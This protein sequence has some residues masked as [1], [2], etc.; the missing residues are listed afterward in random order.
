MSK[1]VPTSDNPPDVVPAASPQ[2][3]L[4][5]SGRL[6]VTQRD[7]DMYAALVGVPQTLLLAEEPPLPASPLRIDRA[8]LSSW[9]RGLSRRA[10]QKFDQ[11]KVRLVES[12][13][14]PR[15]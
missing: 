15:A 2:G 4:R 14:K 7:L 6:R 13:R 3:A 11:A 5:G 1:P 10:R 8:R 12:T 9:V